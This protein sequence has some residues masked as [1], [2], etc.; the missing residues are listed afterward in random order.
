MTVYVWQVSGIQCMLSPSSCPR[1]LVVLAS[2]FC[3]PTTSTSI[4]SNLSQVLFSLF[5]FLE[6]CSKLINQSVVSY[7]S[8]FRQMVCVILPALMFLSFI[9]FMWLTFIGFFLNL[10]VCTNL[11]FNLFTLECCY[12]DAHFRTNMYDCALVSS[13]C[14]RCILGC[15]Y[16]EYGQHY[17]VSVVFVMC[18]CC[19]NL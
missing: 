19:V 18:M 3:K 10:Q 14:G 13:L 9:I 11:L 17:V 2:I 6:T 8:K 5:F 4:A 12:H 1:P 16:M 15:Q 7:N